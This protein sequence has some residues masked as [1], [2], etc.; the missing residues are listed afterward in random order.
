MKDNVF[1]CEILKEIVTKYKQ[2]RDGHCLI[3]LAALP[4]SGQHRRGR[5]SVEYQ[6][7]NNKTFSNNKPSKWISKTRKH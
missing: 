3:I 5:I 1:M 2:I 6:L 4:S 7:Q